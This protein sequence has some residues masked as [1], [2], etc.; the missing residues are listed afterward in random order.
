[1]NYRMM[2]KF[3]YRILIIEWIFMIPALLISFYY[4]ETHAVH[5]Y[6]L[7]LA[8]IA[9]II[10]LLYLMCK[11]APSG[12]YAKDGLTCVGI[13]WIVMGLLGC[14]PFYFSGEIPAFIDAFFEI[15][16]GFT[17]TGSSIVPEVEK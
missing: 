5:G 2:G 15:V 8:I 16:S 6:L 12:F 4:H 14:L 10:L 17:T 11:D 13:S 7:S 1:M 9:G 3:I